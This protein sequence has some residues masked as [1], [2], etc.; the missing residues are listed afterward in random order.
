MK[1]KEFFCLD[2]YND[3]HIMMLQKFEKDN[4]LDTNLSSQLL[5]ERQCYSQEEYV[6]NYHTKNELYQQFCYCKDNIIISHCIFYI[7]KDIKSCHI[8]FTKSHKTPKSIKIIPL[9]TEYALDI[10]GMEE[11]FS[12]TPAVDSTLSNLLLSNGYENLGIDEG[13]SSFVIEKS[14]LDTMRKK[15][16]G[17]I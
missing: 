17:S 15:N 9:A 5:A 8:T 4:N 14:Q 3:T 1:A 16:N 7:Q 6:R 2:P 10:L 13:I 12:S 11:V